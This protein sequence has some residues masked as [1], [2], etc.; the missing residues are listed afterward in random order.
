[1]NA[2][3]MGQCSR[4]IV[5]SAIL[6]ASPPA[7]ADDREARDL[8]ARADQ[9]LAQGDVRGAIGFLERADALAPD[10]STV[11]KIAQAYDKLASED[12]SADNVRL[13]I[14]NYRQYLETGPHPS[15]AAIVERVDA[16]KEQLN[17][18]LN[19]TLKPPEP[20]RSDRIPVAFYGELSAY[21]F[22]VTVDGQ[23]C[24]TPCTLFL[25][26][27]PTKIEA[28]GYEHM[29]LDLYVPRA[30]SEVMLKP[31]GERFFVPGIVLTAVGVV[32][33]GGG[34]TFQYACPGGGL[35]FPINPCA[36]TNVIVWPIVGGA[37]AFTGVGL[38]ASYSLHLGSRSEVIVVD[39]DASPSFQLASVGFQPLAHGGAAGA[40]FSF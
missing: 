1:M 39:S 30:Q 28:T 17:R 7:R 2:S 36:T 5:V 35:D 33:A 12:D 38:L 22:T 34:W 27:G 3:G 31:A 23:S 8:I 29:N 19:A 21:H 9:R 13:A 11:L 32:V 26:P 14:V 10:P 6:A 24:Q 4:I 20:V 25:Q 16:L 15:P 40:V 37:L 18:R